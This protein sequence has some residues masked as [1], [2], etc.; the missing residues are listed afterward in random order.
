MD[1]VNSWRKDARDET[2]TAKEAK[3]ISSQNYANK[4]G[5]RKYDIP[6]VISTCAQRQSQL[7]SAEA[8][9]FGMTQYELL[10]KPW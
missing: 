6:K 9:L 7:M 4:N 5:V 1:F 3:D 8:S 2:R 10:P